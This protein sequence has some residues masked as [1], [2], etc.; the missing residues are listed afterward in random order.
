MASAAG[1]K[2]M[3]T[4]LL[5]PFY[6]DGRLDPRVR[7]A[8]ESVLLRVL[9]SGWLSSTARLAVK[10]RGGVIS[11][12]TRLSAERR[13][14]VSMSYAYR[15]RSEC[16]LD[17]ASTYPGGDYLE[18]GSTS[19]ATF[20]SFL[21]A[22]HL[23]HGETGFPDTRFYAFDIFGDPDQ[24]SS[25]PTGDRDYFEGHRAAVEHSMDLASL[26][27]YGRLKDR[28]VMVPGYYQDT[29]NDALKQQRKAENRRVGFAFLDCSLGSSY[30]TV[31]DFLLDV[32]GPERMFIYMDEYFID[33]KPSVHS[34]YR[35]FAAEAKRR[36]DFDS[37]YMRN[38]AGCGALFSLMPSRL[39]CRRRSRRAAPIR[40]PDRRRTSARVNAP[41]LIRVSSRGTKLGI[42][43]GREARSKIL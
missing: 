32:I 39:S 21:G 28:C 26:E 36:Y 40:R 24:G 42:D 10:D 7:R 11:P 8:A 19:L 2:P 1:N 6:R 33:A 3:G 23:H 12:A 20:R 4:G 18:F 13:S 43:R 9:P 38:A 29:L 35:D 41:V 31:F 34:L 15:A 22:F 25:G 14:L 16:A 30:K 27:E 17:V 5:A 37:L